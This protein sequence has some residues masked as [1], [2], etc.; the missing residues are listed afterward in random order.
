MT[1][2][3]IEGILISF[4]VVITFALVFVIIIYNAKT[5]RQ[6]DEIK[7]YQMYTKPLEEL[8]KEIRARQHEFDNHLNAILNMHLTVDNYN[9]LVRAQ[10]DYIFSI[11]DNKKNNYMPLLRLSDK[12]LAGF[13]YTKLSSVVKAVEF[14]VELGAETIITNV[15]ERDIIEVIGTLIDNA[16]DACD[17]ENYH[18]RIFISSKGHDT[19]YTDDDRIIFEILNEHPVVSVADFQHFFEKGWSTKSDSSY[20]RGFGLYNA[21]RIV[22]QN[23]GEITVENKEIDGRN[24]VDFRIEM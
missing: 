21:K 2:E 9:E 3:Q 10:S 16:V 20:R 23:K 17:D 6:Q 18:I 4:I 14:E 7:L 15:S 5:R 8:I 11:V 1:P 19:P 12:V 13:L 24:Y 22:S